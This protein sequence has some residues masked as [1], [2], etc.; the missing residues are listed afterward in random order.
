MNGQSR[1]Q[2]ETCRLER[3]TGSWSRGPPG[4]GL[5]GHFQRASLGSPAGRCETWKSCLMAFARS[6]LPVICSFVFAC[7]IFYK[8]LSELKVRL[9]RSILWIEQLL[10]LRTAIPLT[11]G[12]SQPKDCDIGIR[13]KDA[14]D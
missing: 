3:K 10:K 7:C 14:M 13:M 6:L 8:Y 2:L 9:W 1:L 5:S 4:R 11:V 12:L